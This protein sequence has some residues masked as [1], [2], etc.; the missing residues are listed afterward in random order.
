MSHRSAYVDFLLGGFSEGE[1]E[2]EE[3]PVVE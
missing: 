2:M 3:G 1:S